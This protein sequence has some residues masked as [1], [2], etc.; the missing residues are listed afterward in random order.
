MVPNP[1]PFG[2]VEPTA[3]PPKI[4]SKDSPPSPPTNFSGTF[5]G[6]S[7]ASP[8]EDPDHPLIH[9]TPPPTGGWRASDLRKREE[10][11][12]EEA[13]KDKKKSS[14]GTSFAERS[15]AASSS[16]SSPASN[17]YISPH[18][19]S[20]EFRRNASMWYA[21]PDL[22]GP[23]PRVNAATYRPAAAPQYWSPDEAHVAMLEARHQL[24]RNRRVHTHGPGARTTRLADAGRSRLVEVRENMLYVGGEP[25]WIQGICYS[26]VPIGESVSFTPKGDYFTPD[27][28]Y[29]WQR[30]L[31]LIKAMGATTL[32]IYGW[33]ANADHTAFLDAVHEAGLKVLVTYYLGDA[34]QNPVSTVDQ[35]NQILIDFVAQV[36]RYADHPAVLMWSFGNEL[37][38]AWNGFAKQFSDAFGCW[39]QAGCAGYSDTNSDCQ[40]Q[41]TCMYHQ[42]FSWINAAC[43]AAK[44]VTTRPIISGFADVDYMVG[45]T[46][47]LDKVARF[48]YALVDMD[49]WA[50]QLYRGY[51]FGGYFGMYR[52]ESSKPMIVTEFG[53]DAYNDACG[54][55]ERNQGGCFNMVGEAA[56]GA[57]DTGH[58]WGCADGGECAKPGVQAQAEWD[59]RLA[60]EL[61]AQY[62]DRGGIVWGGFLMAWTDEYWKGG[63]TQDLCAAPCK[64]W[65]EAWCRG[66]GIDAYRPG[67]SAMCSWRAHF[68]CPNFDTNYHDLCG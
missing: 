35:R 4:E 22:H 27:Y 29:I 9:L 65:D 58:F 28:A 40:W 25:F 20:E 16:S 32:R 19:P 44:I 24:L 12:A 45:P 5:S 57:D 13:Q 10:R 2:P 26:P 42:L 54:W 14:G 41:S 43:R 68:T 33:A 15:G 30:D 39:W 59:V 56:G 55:P 31:P 61:M 50:V 60:N 17:S 67:G 7:T 49:A 1:P 64:T 34:T 18:G 21:P 38:G 47:W 11:H 52:G 51:S 8:S 53:V 23:M 46:P 66:A 6:D 3:T 48:N 63:G 62:V 36:H 37:N